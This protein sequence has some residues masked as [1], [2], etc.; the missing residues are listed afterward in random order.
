MAPDCGSVEDMVTDGLIN[1]KK[2]LSKDLFINRYLSAFYQIYIYH[3]CELCLF[4]VK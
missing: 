3:E 2:G 4:P 1:T